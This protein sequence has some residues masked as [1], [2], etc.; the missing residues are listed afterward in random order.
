MGRPS[1]GKLAAKDTL[2]KQHMF[3]VKGV[4]NTATNSD[5]DIAKAPNAVSQLYPAQPADTTKCG[6]SYLVLTV[7]GTAK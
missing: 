2:G 3:G 7:R 4:G 1:I 5:A 6:A